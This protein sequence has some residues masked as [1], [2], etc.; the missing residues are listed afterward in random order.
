MFSGSTLFDIFGSWWGVFEF[1]VLF[2]TV[3]A[4]SYIGGR[5]LQSNFTRDE[6]SERLE[7]PLGGD[8]KKLFN[9]VMSSVDTAMADAIKIS[10]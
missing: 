4:I 5:I 10:K 9:A 3:N 1:V 2:A 7:T 8:E 6:K